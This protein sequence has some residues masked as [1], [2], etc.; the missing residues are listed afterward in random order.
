MNNKAALK[1]QNISL[2]TTVKLGNIHLWNSH[3]SLLC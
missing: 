3:F 2:F 1:Y